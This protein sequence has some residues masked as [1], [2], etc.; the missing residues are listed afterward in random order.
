MRQMMM[1]NV[2]SMLHILHH[3]MLTEKLI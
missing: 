3:G 2:Q 1:E